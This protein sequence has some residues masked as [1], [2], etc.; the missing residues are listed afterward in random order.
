[1]KGESYEYI[2]LCVNRCCN[3]YYC[4]RVDNK[5]DIVVVQNHYN[6]SNIGESQCRD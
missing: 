6:T 3:C 5:K 4:R 2:E 1:M